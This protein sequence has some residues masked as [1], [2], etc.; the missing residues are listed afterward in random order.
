HSCALGPADTRFRSPPPCSIPHGCRPPPQAIGIA[1]TGLIWSAASGPQRAA[2]PLRS[3]DG[4]Q[5]VTCEGVGITQIVESVDEKGS[6][7]SGLAPTTRAPGSWRSVVASNRGNRLAS[8][9]VSSTRLLP[10][11]RAPTGRVCQTTVELPERRRHDVTEGRPGGCLLERQDGRLR[12]DI[13][14]WDADVLSK[15]TTGEAAVP[16]NFHP[17]DGS[18]SPPCPQLP[19]GRRNH[20]RGSWLS[21]H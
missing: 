21:A 2:R 4:W 17:R 14:L 16:E 3:I 11:G 20:G 13:V 9:E 7:R 1:T 15:L 6:P 19:R 5:Q 8:E 12:L 18:A 10:I